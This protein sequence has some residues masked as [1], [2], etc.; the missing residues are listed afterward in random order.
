MGVK[1]DAWIVCAQ[2]ASGEFPAFDEQLASGR[3][4]T[5]TKEA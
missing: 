5:S 1:T 2:I 4:S 3:P